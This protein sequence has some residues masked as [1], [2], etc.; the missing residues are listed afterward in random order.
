MPDPIA[1]NDILDLV[2]A[3]IYVVERQ[4]NGVFQ[5]THANLLAACYL[6]VRG[7]L[8]GKTAEQAVAGPDGPRLEALHR[9]VFETNQDPQAV[10]PRPSGDTRVLLKALKPGLGRVRRAVATLTL[11]EGRLSADNPMQLISLAGH[12]LQGPLR[13]IRVLIDLVQETGAVSTDQAELLDA[14]RQMANRAEASIRDVVT[15]SFA[16]AEEREA[17][18]IKLQDMVADIMD[19][20]DPDMIANVDASPVT[21]T[22][23]RLVLDGILR[24]LL[25]RCLTPLKPKA[26]ALVEIAANDNVLDFHITATD[27]ELLPDERQLLEGGRA[28]SGLPFGLLGAREVCRKNGGTLGLVENDDEVVLRFTLPGRAVA[29]D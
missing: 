16:A 26:A 17:S 8:I 28:R 18:Q 23:P 29:I 4:R 1:P 19:V 25:K 5:I 7:E 12:Q 21:V 14:V 11:S 22:A 20:L 27:L 9:A 3:G 24:S 6:G 13:N 15:Y 2:D 10:L